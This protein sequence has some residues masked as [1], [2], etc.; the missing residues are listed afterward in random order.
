MVTTT[1]GQSDPVVWVTTAQGT[2]VL[3]GFDG[4]TGASVFTGGGVTM[5]Q[6]IRW[7]NPIVAEGRL[8]VAAT[9][10]LYAFEAP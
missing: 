8:Y 10:K 2:N 4:D 5:T 9:G 7:T 1:D 3:L 6:I